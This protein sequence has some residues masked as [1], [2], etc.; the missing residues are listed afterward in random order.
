METNPQTLKEII[1]IMNSTDWWMFGITAVSV[2]ISGILSYML[3]RLTKNLGKQQNTIQQNNL[4]IQM[5]KEYFEIY[6]ALMKDFAQID[7]LPHQFRNVLDGKG[8]CKLDEC[9]TKNTLVRMRQLLPTND[10]NILTK[11]EEDY[12]YIFSNTEHMYH[13]TGQ[14]FK[15][16]QNVLKHI[17]E[18]NGFESFLEELSNIRDCFDIDEYLARIKNIEKCKSSNFIER[19]RSYSDLSDVIQNK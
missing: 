12:M 1:D 7:S 11:F 10:Y 14:C 3:Y 17:L 18:K 13:Y 5:H 16:K 8:G 15:E 6:D 2:V 4:R 9:C 19:M